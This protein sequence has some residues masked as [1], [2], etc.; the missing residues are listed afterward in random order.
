MSMLGFACSYTT[1]KDVER[2]SP[3]GRRAIAHE[4]GPQRCLG[5]RVVEWL[6]DVYGGKYPDRAESTYGLFFAAMLVV[7]IVWSARSAIDLLAGDHRDDAIVPLILYLALTGVFGG[8]TLGFRYGNPIGGKLWLIFSPACSAALFLTGRNILI[9]VRSPYT[10]SLVDAL[11]AVADFAIAVLIL[12]G[13]ITF[14]LHYAGKSRWATATTIAC[15]F[16]TVLVVLGGVALA[17]VS[18]GEKSTLLVICA[19]LVGLAIAV[20]GMSRLKKLARTLRV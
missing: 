11:S 3:C 19:V 15:E 13:W 4:Q 17:V 6:V 20:R 12:S 8:L 5:H 9:S 18:R 2:T 10:P 16:L 1:S 7:A 14:L